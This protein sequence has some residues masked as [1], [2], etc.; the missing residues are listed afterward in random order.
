MQIQPL[1]VYLFYVGGVL[2][3]RFRSDGVGWVNDWGLARSSELKCQAAIRTRPEAPAEPHRR[4]L[5]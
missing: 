3:S 4:Y 2:Y 5:H 1:M